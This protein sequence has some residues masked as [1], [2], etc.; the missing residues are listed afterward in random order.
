MIRPG[1]IDSLLKS[2]LF[3]ELKRNE[4]QE[5]GKRIAEAMFG[6]IGVIYSGPEYESVVIRT[7][8]QFNENSKFLCLT[9]VIPEMNHNELVGWGGGDDRFSVLF[10]DGE[11]ISGRNKVRMDISRE[12]IARKT[13]HV[14]TINASGSSHLERCIYLIHIVDWASFY[15]NELTGADI[16]DIKVIDHL[17]GELSKI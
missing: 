1:R 2:A 11:D 14:L 15:L 9:H 8:Q 12:I 6:K 5:V 4:I 3:L 10:I 7:R 17:K 13:P 16:L